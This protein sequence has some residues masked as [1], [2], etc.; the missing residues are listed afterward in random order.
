M[1]KVRTNRFY[2]EL[3]I[4]KEDNGKKKT[5]LSQNWNK[6]VRHYSVE[7]ATLHEWICLLSS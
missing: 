5:H 4:S 6:S 3:K 7:T 2:Y 1:G